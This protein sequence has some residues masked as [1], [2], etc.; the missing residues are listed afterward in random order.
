M[1]AVN[2]VDFIKAPDLCEQLGGTYDALEI[3]CEHKQ[4]GE[5]FCGQVDGLGSFFDLVAEWIDLEGSYDNA[6]C[7][8]MAVDEAIEPEDE[9]FGRPDR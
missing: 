2:C 6:V 7:G 4:E 8:G 5:F 3:G 9:D 1:Y